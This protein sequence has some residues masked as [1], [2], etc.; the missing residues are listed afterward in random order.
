MASTQQKPT[1]CAGGF[2]EQYWS[3]ELL[4]SF[5]LQNSADIDEVV[6]GSHQARPSAACRL[7]L[8]SATVEPVSP[9]DHMH[10][11]ILQISANWP[12]LAIPQ[13]RSCVGK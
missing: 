4:A 5:L 12:I 13:C 9:L 7:R 2:C 1:R 6:G 8:C 11:P 10:C 3:R